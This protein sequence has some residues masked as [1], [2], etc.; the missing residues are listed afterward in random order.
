MFGSEVRAGALA[1]LAMLVGGAA[2]AL[3]TDAPEAPD[4][5]ELVASYLSPAGRVDPGATPAFLA[6]AELQL[7]ALG[8]GLADVTFRAVVVAALA[9]AD[10]ATTTATRSGALPRDLDG[11]VS[12]EVRC[13]GAGAAGVA[14]LEARV[15]GGVLAPIV[16][17]HATGCV[18]WALGP[19][20]ARFDGEVLLYRHD[21]ADVIVRL[22][23]QLTVDAPE[24]SRPPDRARVTLDFRLS[25]VGLETR[26]PTPNG[27]VIAA[28]A[29]D[30]WEIEAR[31]ANGRFRCS[32]LAGTCRPRTE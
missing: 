9:Q 2:C 10:L 20:S 1:V 30:A 19:V 29:R 21:D 26:V 17:G 24:A 8:G 14:V 4:S 5:A 23:G 6:S 13:A 27:D 28:R 18:L 3:P 22:R 31:A 32:P 7:A 16:W 25:A 11:T 15:V 12:L